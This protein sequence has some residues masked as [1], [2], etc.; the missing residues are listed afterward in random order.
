MTTT[1]TTIQMQK[2]CASCLKEN[3][4]L[5]ENAHCKACV[6]AI[7]ELEEF[8]ANQPCKGGCGKADKD[9]E[10]PVTECEYCL[11]VYKVADGYGSFCS[12]YCLNAMEGVHCYCCYD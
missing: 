12:R 11:T 7:A 4:E 6:I 8:L 1:M 5:D 3:G 10:C 9:C 2:F